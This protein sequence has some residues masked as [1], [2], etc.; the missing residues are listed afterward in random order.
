[1]RDEIGK[2]LP[3]GIAVGFEKQ[4]PKEIENMK[5]DMNTL[6][7][8]ITPKFDSKTTSQQQQGNT[9]INQTINS[10]AVL[11]PY[12]IGQETKNTFNRARWQLA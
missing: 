2:F 11:S 12:E 4:M 5:A 7:D 9:I 10:K 6:V 3:M 8:D 1:M